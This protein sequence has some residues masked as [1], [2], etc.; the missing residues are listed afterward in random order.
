MLLLLSLFRTE[1]KPLRNDMSCPLGR[2]PSTCTKIESRDRTCKKSRSETPRVDVVGNFCFRL[3]GNNCRRARSSKTEICRVSSRSMS[4]T[5]KT[6]A[7]D[8]HE[9]SRRWQ[10]SLCLCSNFARS[11]SPSSLS[12]EERTVDL[13]CNLEVGNMAAVNVLHT[14]VSTGNVSR[15]EM[16]EWINSTLHFNYTKVE[17]MCSGEKLSSLPEIMNLL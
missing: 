5:D 1:K 4:D 15:H 9:P 7:S 8:F 10:H 2:R 12:F 17:Q 11:T 14:A 6:V 16:L 13:V 3:H